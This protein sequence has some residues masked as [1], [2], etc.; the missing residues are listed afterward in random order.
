LSNAIRLDITVVVLA[1][2]DE[3]TIGFHHISNHIVNKSVFI[4][5][6]LGFEFLLVLLVIDGLENILE[7]T[8]ILLQD[9][10]LGGHVEGIVSVK[11]IFEA[12]VGESRD[13]FVGVIHTNTDTTSGVLKDIVDFLLGSVRGDEVDFEFASLLSDKVSGLVLV[14]EGM[15]ANN[16]GLFPAGNVSGDTVDDDGLSEDGTLKIVSNGSVGGFPH[17]LEVEF[18]DSG[19]IRSDGG[20]LDTDLAFL[21]GLGSV[22]GDLV[23]SLISVFHTKI[24]VLDVQV[25]EGEDKLILDELPDDSG[26]LVTVKLSNGI[27]DLNFLEFH[28]EGLRVSFLG[29]R[30]LCEKSFR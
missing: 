1:G 14:T 21:D 25:K 5:E 6:A 30:V 18:L 16:D 29:K 12:G 7:S 24:K 17:L 11:G 28:F 3:T 2:P 22:K 20:A 19:L 9:G 26:H 27:F 23:V 8:V 4:P 15:S 10:V 13:R